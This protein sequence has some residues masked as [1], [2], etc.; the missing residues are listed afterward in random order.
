M[1]ISD[2]GIDSSRYQLIPRVLIYLR[3][4]DSYLL[5]KGS[6]GRKRWPGKY[7]GVGGHLERGEDVLTAARRE[8]EEETGLQASLWLCGTI[9]A[10]TGHIGVGLYVFS[11]DVTGGSLSG[12]KEGVP[13]WV[14]YDRVATL[15]AVEDMPDLLARIHRMQRGDAP[16]AARS[17]YDP[18]G[19]LQL[20]FSN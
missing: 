9:V 12:S 7:N 8:L 3:E 13:E 16:F 11:G 4:G 1:P 18:E 6:A 5:V 19:R 10:D 20:V 14:D 17:F 15:P 2:Q